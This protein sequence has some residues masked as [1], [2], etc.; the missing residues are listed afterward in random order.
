MLKTKTG[1][2]LCHYSLVA[3]FILLKLDKDYSCGSKCK[4]RRV[5]FY[6]DEKN[7]GRVFGLVYLM[8]N[9][10]SLTFNPI[11]IHGN[12]IFVEMEV[13]LLEEELFAK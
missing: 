10:V 6:G 3:S 2:K 8:K 12:K 5:V 1:G 4:N 11:S 9:K 7:S 13:H